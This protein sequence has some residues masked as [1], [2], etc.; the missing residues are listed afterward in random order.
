MVKFDKIL[1]NV[2]E[3]KNITAFLILMT[4]LVI[5]II[6][7]FLESLT[8]LRWDIENFTVYSEDNIEISGNIY[9]P[10]DL[11]AESKYPTLIHCHSLTGS[12]YEDEYLRYNLLEHG[13]IVVTFDFRG[14]GSS[15]GGVEVDKSYIVEV[16][17]NNAKLGLDIEAVLDFILI[18]DLVDN[19]SI[20]LYGRSL[21]GGVLSYYSYIDSLEEH[22]RIKASVAI[23]YL[24]EYYNYLGM[25]ETNPRN[26]LAI[27]GAHDEF[28]TVDQMNLSLKILTGK[29]NAEFGILYGNFSDDTAREVNVIPG[30]GHTNFGSFLPTINETAKWFERAFYG[31]I[32]NKSVFQQDVFYS[33]VGNLNMI[34]AYGLQIIIVY[35]LGY[36]FFLKSKKSKRTKEDKSLKI[37]IENKNPLYLYFVFIFLASLIAIGLQ[38]FLPVPKLGAPIFISFLISSIFLTI[39]AVKWKGESLNLISIFKYMKRS[40]KED[41]L[42]H[43]FIVILS[44]MALIIIGILN[45]YWINNRYRTLYE[46]FP[47][48]IYTIVLFFSNL[49]NQIY[50]F[51]GFGGHRNKIIDFNCKVSLMNLIFAYLFQCLLIVFYMMIG[52]VHFLNTFLLIPYLTTNIF[53]IIFMI[54]IFY[55][56]RSI[57]LSSLIPAIYMGWFMSVVMPFLAIF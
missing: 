30:V 35:F 40:I 57:F 39:C 7:I 53:A 2:V 21:G 29:D 26:F 17:A 52:L 5:F 43:L 18:Q 37:L 11:D 45:F 55:Q 13:F 24:G 51:R 46:I 23:S 44:S 10:K 27:I 56:T 4:L 41:F 32:S 8:E 49:F 25:N 34:S 3:R 28:F 47:I 31:E 54:I 20:G 38:Y 33:F 1:S 12:R 6:T 42:N 15:L 16:F 50:L 22:P 36:A 48:V 14:H 9:Y 19:E